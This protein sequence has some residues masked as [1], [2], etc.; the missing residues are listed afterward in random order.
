MPYIVKALH[1]PDARLRQAGMNAIHGI[2]QWWFYRRSKENGIGM[3]DLT[4]EVLSCLL[5]P[6]KDPNAPMWEKVSA[7]WALG[8]ADAET[9]LA[10]L[11]PI[12][13]H[14]QHDDWWVRVAAWEALNPLSADPEQLKIVLPD[15]LACY[16]NE[17]IV[18]PNRSMMG[19][20][21]T[22][23]M[24]HASL[25]EAIIAGMAKAADEQSIQ[26]G[27]KEHVYVNKI[28]EP[29]RY[30]DM[31]KHPEHAI[32]MLNSAQRVLKHLAGSQQVPWLFTGARWGNIGLV[33]CANQLGEDAKPIIAGLKAMLP[34]IE[35]AA[36]GRQK[37]KIEE[38]LDTVKQCIADYE[39]KYGTVAAAHGPVEPA[40]PGSAEGSKTH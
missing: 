19:R 22:M 15:L 13:A 18:H 4:D 27:Y 2:Y 16:A 14:L 3:Q 34:D 36:T 8:K 32:P 24:T 33:N 31:K 11:E 12:K 20:L 21:K 40:P 1:S 35:K 7:L 23:H 17:L 10:N 5:K 25:R 29:L 39:T 38:T 6:V 28:Y 30:L 26:G 9:I 37:E